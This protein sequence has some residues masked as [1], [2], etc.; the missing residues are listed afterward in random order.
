MISTVDLRRDWVVQRSCRFAL[1]L[2]LGYLFTGGS[3]RASA[4]SIVYSF[5]GNL[6]TNATS[7]GCGSGCTL[8]SSNT[9]GDY[10]QWAAVVETFI[11]GV[12]STM[13]AMTFS[14][15]GGTNGASASIAQG[16]F[17][18]YLSLFDSA[19]HF[20]AST[21][22]GTVCPT[23]AQT[24]SNSGQCLD[25][26]LNGGT[27]A[28]GTYQIAISAFENMSSAENSGAGTL[29]DGFTGLGNLAPGEDLHFAVDVTLNNASGPSVPEPATRWLLPP[30]LAFTYFARNFR[31]GRS[32]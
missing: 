10:A 3:K 13:Q 31:K 28:P 20:L 8:G 17:E 9:D 5:T 24:N 14:Y 19:G 2:M 21:F 4:S 25:V 7:I 29:A 23:G 18:P 12:T 30:S 11:V 15:G 1:I 27:L 16:G 26:S 22:F 6:R 32:I